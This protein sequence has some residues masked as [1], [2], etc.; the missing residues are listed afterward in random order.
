MREK[1]G[2][3]LAG[4]DVSVFPPPDTELLAFITKILK[5]LGSPLTD[6]LEARSGVRA[7]HIAQAR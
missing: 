4:A 2:V 6:E 7:G 5:S 3:S 1:K